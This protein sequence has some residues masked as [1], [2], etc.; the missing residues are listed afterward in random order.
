MKRVAFLKL[1]ALHQKSERWKDLVGIGTMDSLVGKFFKRQFILIIDWL[2]IPQIR[3]I[4]I[5]RNPTFSN[6][7]IKDND[8]SSGVANEYKPNDNLHHE[9]L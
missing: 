3:K 4:G 6:Y 5:L 8:Y 9:C 1:L 7:N 2:K